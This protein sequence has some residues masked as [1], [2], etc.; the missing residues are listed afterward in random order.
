MT[1][2]PSS[3]KTTPKRNTWLERISQIFLGVPQDK[4]DLFETF[5]QAHHRNIIDHD[6]LR[7]LEGALAV[8]ELQLRDIMIPRSQVIWFSQD[9]TLETIL[10]IVKDTAHSRYPV[11]GESRDEVVGVL[12]AKDLLKAVA[13]GSENF[14]LSHYMRPPIFV[15]ESKRCDVMLR[16]F[17]RSQ[18]HMAIVIDEYGH[19]AG[20][21]TIEDVLEQIVGEIED[22]HDSE[23]ENLILPIISDGNTPT[24]SI[25]ALT[26]VEDFNE[27]FSSRL[28]QEDFDTIGGLVTHTM[29]Y[30][31]KKGERVQIGGFNFE[32][33][34]ADKRRIK[35]LRLKVKK[36]SNYSA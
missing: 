22:E 3:Q 21:V 19:V 25:N 23:E 30:L 34:T 12:L 7:L 17:Q 10:P 16:E 31:P 14:K 32:V 4:K 28:N 24:Y 2:D 5:K 35:T 18:N 8:S 33:V 36:K 20:L 13:N 29:G 27:R 15:P 1:D 11:L 26:P 9:D 6:D